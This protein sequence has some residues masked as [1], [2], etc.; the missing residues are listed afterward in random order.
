MIW[1][2][3]EKKEKEWKLCFAFLPKPIGTYPLIDGQKMVWLE[4]IERK[5]IDSRNGSNSYEY[6][7][8]LKK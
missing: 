6:R 8:R 2:Y 5:F 7:L 3:K 1:N 4:L